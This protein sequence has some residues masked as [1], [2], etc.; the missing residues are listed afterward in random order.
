VSGGRRSRGPRNLDLSGRDLAI[1]TSIGR[2]R[3]L[4]AGQ[5]ERL[6]FTGHHVSQMSAR[7]RCQAV[8][9]RLARAELL[10][11]LE[12][13]AGGVRAGSTGFIYRLTTRGRRAIG[14]RGR[15]TRRQP[16]ERWTDHTL[17]CAE[18]AVRLQATQVAGLV[19]AM[20]ITPEP[21]TWRRFI[22]PR[23][24]VEVLKPDLLVE[25][26]TTTRL[27][28]RWFVEVDRAT[29]HLPVILRKCQQYE[30]YWRSGSE[31][32]P[33]FPRVLWSVPDESRALA[34]TGLI[35]QNRG[36]TPALFV[37]AT[38]EQTTSLLLGQHPTS[39][40]T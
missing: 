30:S 28:L 13:R 24:Q 39:S 29:E 14:D 7:R 25:V 16:H 38:T 27:E 5:I 37:V 40:S 10:D 22:A 26:I 35:E 17:D 12:R 11:R 2:Y 33:V 9:R 20:T 31:A 1:L 23:N 4:S 32:H 15:G 3:L 36:L 6:H 34:I 18:I 19:T 8:L 21:A